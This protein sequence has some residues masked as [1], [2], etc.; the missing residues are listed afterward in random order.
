[1]AGDHTTFWLFSEDGKNINVDLS[2][3]GLGTT[4]SGMYGLKF[5]GWIPNTTK[6][7]IIALS[8]NDK[9]YE[10]TFDASTGFQIVDTIE[11]KN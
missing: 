11:I 9:T 5:G 10:A 1:M 2:K 8:S 6:F 4:I 3:M 7:K